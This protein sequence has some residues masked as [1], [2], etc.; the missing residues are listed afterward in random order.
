MYKAASKNSPAKLSHCDQLHAQ[1]F[2]NFSIISDLSP[3]SKWDDPLH[4]GPK[5]TIF[6]LCEMFAQHSFSNSI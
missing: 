3:W 5:S 1:G 6:N 2:W 4:I